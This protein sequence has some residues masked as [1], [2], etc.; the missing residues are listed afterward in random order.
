MSLL[1][2]C[3]TNTFVGEHAEYQCKIN[4]NVHEIY[5]LQPYCL[6]LRLSAVYNL[7]GLLCGIELAK[8]PLASFKYST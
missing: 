1:S 6:A 7:I 3:L 8:R 5:Y 2:Q 4:R